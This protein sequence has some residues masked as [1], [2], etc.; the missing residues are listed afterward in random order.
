LSIS[1]GFA[2]YIFG[3]RILIGIKDGGDQSDF[4]YDSN[5]GN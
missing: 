3:K 4:I 1:L 5:V 2:K